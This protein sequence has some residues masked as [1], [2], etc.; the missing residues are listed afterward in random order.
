MKTKN[1]LAWI[2]AVLL[3]LAFLMAGITKITGQA[4][5]VLNFERWGI[6]KNMMYFIGLCEIA[7]AVGMYLKKWRAL[8]AIGLA[9]LLLGAIGTHIRVGEPFIPPLV[10]L[11]LSGLLVWLRKEELLNLRKQGFK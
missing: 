6:S 9:L 1:I 7:A 11:I 5:M 4:E 10:L 8:A 3:S 2:I